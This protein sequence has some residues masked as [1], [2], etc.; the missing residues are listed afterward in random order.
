M[1]ILIL[2]EARV[3]ISCHIRTTLPKFNANEKLDGGE[4]AG[5]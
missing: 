3:N 1:V 4:L 5:D 2:L